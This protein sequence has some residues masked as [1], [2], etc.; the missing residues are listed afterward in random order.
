MATVG[1]LEAYFKQARL[2]QIA[3]SREDQPW[4][5]TVY[6]VFHEGKFYWLSW[7]ERRHSQELAANSKIAVAIA[8]KADLPVMGVQ[9]EG[10]AQL[11]TDR[12]LVRSVMERYIT[13]YDGAGSDFYERF[14][15]G[16]NH[17]ALYRVV[18]A[19]AIL[20]DEVHYPKNGRQELGV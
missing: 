10:E 6:F 20:F 9:I 17:H 1:E 8:L 5:C 7:P 12:S 13:K 11:V 2:M 14:V 4:I 18:P 16:E 3:T 19:N 15:R